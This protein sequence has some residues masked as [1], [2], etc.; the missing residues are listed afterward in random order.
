MITMQSIRTLPAMLGVCL[1]SSC[2]KPALGQELGDA[3]AG[4]MFAQ[5]VCA[6]CHAVNPKQT[7]SPNPR[8]AT[9]ET[10]ANTPGV[11]AI[12]LTAWLQTSHKEM[13]NII[14]PVRDRENLIAYILSLKNP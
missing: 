13:P 5:L 3:R 12:A 7:V 2:I 6:D 8:L 14:V 4:Q 10:I 9:F 1:L 11:T